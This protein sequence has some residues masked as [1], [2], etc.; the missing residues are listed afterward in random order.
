LDGDI[1]DGTTYKIDSVFFFPHDV[2]EE[3]TVVDGLGQRL[4]LN[5]DNVRGGG[6]Q[7]RVSVFALYWI[8]NCTEHPLRYRQEKSNTFVSGTVHSPEKDGSL[9]LSGGRSRANYG[10]LK[11][12]GDSLH[13]HT[14]KTS[15]T[16]FSGTFGALATSPG[17]CDHPPEKVAKIIDTNLPLENLASLAF[18]FN[19][20]EGSVIAMGSQRLCVQ[21]GDGTGKTNYESDWSRGLSIDSVGISQI[22]G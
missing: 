12:D 3:T 4:T 8:I 11:D 14:S 2:A 1:T 18:M 9:P 15:E 20:Q 17:R 13:P 6:G 10:Y 19:F 5:I 7:R 22:V 16:I 21:L